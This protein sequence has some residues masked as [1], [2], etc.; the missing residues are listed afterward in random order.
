MGQ[1]NAAMACSRTSEAIMF[2]HED[3]GYL[4]TSYLDDLIGVAAVSFGSEAYES[5]GK[6][7]LDLGL[8]EN[9]EKH[10]HHPQYK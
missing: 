9:K 3:D 6:L 4:G 1:R 8:L 7:L 5:L 10:V 2:M